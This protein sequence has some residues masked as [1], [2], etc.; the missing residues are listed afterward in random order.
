MY[1]VIVNYSTIY[2]RI[3][4][5]MHAGG[6]TDAGQAGGGALVRQDSAA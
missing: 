1:I 6:H 4:N 5:L 2:D 3:L